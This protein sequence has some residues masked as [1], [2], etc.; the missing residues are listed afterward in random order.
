MSRLIDRLRLRFRSL[1]RG[2]EVEASLKSEIQLHLQEAID[3]EVARGMSPA[4]AREAALR[5]FGP[6]E[7]IEEEC[8]DTRRVAFVE[9]LSQDLRYALRSLLRQPL[10]MS[11]SVL[12]IALAI[13]VNTAIFSLANELMVAMPSAVHPEEL[14]RIRMRGGSHV[15][16]RQWRDLAE[17]GALASLAGFNIES[18]VNWRG[19]DQ[20]LSLMPLIVTDN[21]FDVLGVP[22][23]LGRGFTAAEAQADLDPA[24]AVVSHR[25]WQRRLG[26]DP[27]VLG[28]VLV[29]NGRPF[30]V[31]G[32]LAADTRSIMGFGLAP[33]VYLPLSRALMPDLDSRG[34]A[35][36]VELVGR[37]REGQRLAEGRAALDAAG[38]R[39]GPGYGA[40]DFGVS[41]F[42]PVGSL[43][44]LG[45]LTNV[46]VF[47]VVLLVAVGLILAIACAN[48]AGLLLSRAAARSR[49]IAVRAALGASRR[50]L[51]QLLLT[52]G[53]WIALGGTIGG[54]L[55]MRVLVGLLA[56]V[57][58]P[59]PL[60]L[61]IHA[62]FD[63]RLLL[64]SVLLTVVT[65]LLCALVPALQ[66]SRHTQV[67]A[68][69]RQESQT[70]TIA[71][72]RW[73]LRNL[74]VVAQVATALVLLVTALLFLRNLAR[75]QDLDPGF[76]TSRTLVAEVGF[77]EGKYTPATRTAWLDRAAERL[78]RLGGVEAASYALGA[79]LT[80]RSGMR[81]GAALDI[82][83]RT[84]TFQASYENN[85]VGPGYF[86]AMSIGV[87]RGRE[88]GDQDAPGAPVVIVVNEEFVRRYLS[89]LEPV[90]ARV[91]LPGPTLAGYYA[92]IVGVVRN[93]KHRTIGEQQP[94]AIYEA[95]A[96]RQSKQRVAHLFV[97]TAPASGATAREVSLAL[98]QLDPSA[99][100][101]VQTMR[102]RLAF[103]FLPSQ[104]GAALLGTLGAVGLT[105]AMVGL[106]AVVSFSVSRR[107][108]EIG[109][110][111]ALGATH[112]AVLRLVLREAFMLAAAG[113][114]IGLAAA[115]FV[116]RP[117]A[118][119]LVTGLRTTDPTSFV[120]TTLLLVLV[121]LAAAWGPARRAMRI[122]PVSALRAE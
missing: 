12:S 102:N 37:L 52:E 73:S 89:D 59:L 115:W 68:L 26:G 57:P 18:N 65:T 120:G 117:L 84:G 100:V 67:P 49:E 91:R 97:R 36:A 28:S 98:A 103:A 19:P 106:F 40:G 80:I 81:S 16:Y 39:V 50:R 4:E 101:D 71:G 41:E 13:G 66:A 111:M 69:K 83:G 104:L 44:N 33:E 75:T 5:A 51:I 1:V 20:T 119:F 114:A 92:Q 93:S 14:V 118:M 110:R 122:D 99:S 3:E 30:T 72:R 21:F 6:V 90:G 8:R 112:G 45:S 79:P 55:L 32:V 54:L 46:G 11:A 27:H 78:R 109:I 24:V 42:A 74:L 62:A 87:V 96:Q 121:S 58:L 25:F 95:Y 43:A 82:E 70:G 47:F 35:A 60:P 94:A 63:R 53:F 107:T 34:N 56:S 64:F 116:T 48:V 76:D 10:L 108:A 15:S 86:G 38:R 2:D 61:E 77:V 29:F 88:F 7:R 85:F 113:S 23:A 31:L 9:H 17:S 22:V 105:L